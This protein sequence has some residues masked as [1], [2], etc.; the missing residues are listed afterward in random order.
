MTN[1]EWIQDFK[2]ALGDLGRDVPRADVLGIM[3]SVSIEVKGVG[4]TSEYDLSSEEPAASAEHFRRQL[5]QIRN[6]RRT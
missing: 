5:V 6:R 3:V 2:G 4:V 1:A